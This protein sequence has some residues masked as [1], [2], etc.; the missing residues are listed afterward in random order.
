MAQVKRRPQRRR[1]VQF[2][3]NDELGERYAVCRQRAKKL[4]LEIN[5][6]SDFEVWFAEQL[7]GIE[8]Q[9]DAIDDQFVSRDKQ[10]CGEGRDEF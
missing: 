10:I 2:T 4:R 6:R 9:L 8:R 1:R 5:F 3:L 7:Q